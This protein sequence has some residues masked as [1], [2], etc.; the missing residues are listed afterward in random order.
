MPTLSAQYL[1]GISANHTI[2]TEIETAFEELT[3]TIKD[4]GDVS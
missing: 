4:L 2:D 3:E 1:E